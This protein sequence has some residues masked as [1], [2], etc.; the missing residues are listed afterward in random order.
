MIKT[1]VN[2]ENAPE[3]KISKSQQ[4]LKKYQN[5]QVRFD[6]NTKTPTAK[7]REQRYKTL[8]K[9]SDDRKN[10]QK[11]P[12]KIQKIPMSPKLPLSN[13][14]PQV[15]IKSR[16]VPEVPF[17]Y[18]NLQPFSN[19]DIENK[20]NN[21]SYQKVMKFQPTKSPLKIIKHI[22]QSNRPKSRF[23]KKIE[24]YKQK[25]NSLNLLKEIEINKNTKKNQGRMVNLNKFESKRDSKTGGS[26]RAPTSI[27]SNLLQRESLESKMPSEKTESENGKE[28]H[29]NKIVR[30][31]TEI[32]EEQMTVMKRPGLRSE[33]EG[34]NREPITALSLIRPVI[35]GEDEEK[36]N[37]KLVKGN[38]MLNSLV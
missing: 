4:K 9:N 25:K 13:L 23:S 6:K 12:L 30:N 8:D 17:C 24:K 10:I 27:A 31:G 2:L 18:N 34:E 38:L 3:S 36:G 32:L 35:V 1:P 15:K 29:R 11:I 33:E 22:P 21:K 37:G 19:Q 20:E 26:T 28:T 5:K 16:L 7:I 14:K